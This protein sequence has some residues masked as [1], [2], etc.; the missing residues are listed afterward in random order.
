MALA[1]RFK[2]LIGWFPMLAF[3]GLTILGLRHWTDK[4]E[5]APVEQVHA[6][7]LDFMASESAQAGAYRNGYYAKFQR[8]SVASKHFEQVCAAMLAAALRDNV[9]PTNYSV[10]M[11]R[12]CR[13]VGKKYPPG[14]LPGVRRLPCWS[15]ELAVARARMKEIKHANP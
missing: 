14:A 5:D 10:P 1:V 9:D 6:K 13:A 2:S 12:R 4:M 3:A 8:E 15:V 11:A 7:F